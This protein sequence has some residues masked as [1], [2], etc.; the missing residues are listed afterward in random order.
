MLTV[1][2]CIGLCELSEDE[3]LAI[4]SHEHIP[5][6]AAAEMGNYLVHTPDGESCIRGMIRDDI[7]WAT[8]S[9]N[10]DRALALKLVLRNFILNH[11]RC[12]ERCRR[13]LRLPERRQI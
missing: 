8:A 3:V 9:G 6:V 4:V 10:R 1:E 7:A 11:P 2:D 5:E 13:D 12:D